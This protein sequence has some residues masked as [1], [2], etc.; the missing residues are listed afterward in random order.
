MRTLPY[1]EGVTG[2]IPKHAQ[3]PAAQAARDAVVEY[4]RAN[5]LML[6]PAAHKIRRRAA[7]TT[8]PE[9]VTVH[10]A[11]WRRVPL[12][13]LTGSP[14]L[15]AKAALA[16]G[17]EVAARGVGA[18]VCVGVHEPRIRAYWVSGKGTGV[19]MNGRK[20]TQAEAKAAL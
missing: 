17:R 12:E 2:P 7:V 9:L 19:V 11:P 3:T 13:S 8:E 14:A 18:A 10:P 16:A 6:D 1:P 4:G 20:V 5:P 15:F